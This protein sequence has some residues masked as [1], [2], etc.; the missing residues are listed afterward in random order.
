MS[1]VQVN[2]DSYSD[3]NLATYVGSDLCK[4]ACAS[5]CKGWL[6]FL[7]MYPLPAILL[8]KPPAFFPPLYAVSEDIAGLGME[9]QETH[10]LPLCSIPL[11]T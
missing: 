2:T 9:L 6:A 10:K 5:L 1:A 3:L 7:W 11:S 4:A 8:G